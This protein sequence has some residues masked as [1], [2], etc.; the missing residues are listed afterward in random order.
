MPKAKKTDG[1]N[2]SEIIKIYLDGL[3]RLERYPDRGY[4][5]I[6]QV[7]HNKLFFI[8]VGTLSEIM[9][10]AKEIIRLKG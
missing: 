4:V 7:D 9:D 5:I 6:I 2:Q 8:E 3:L 10:D 1:I